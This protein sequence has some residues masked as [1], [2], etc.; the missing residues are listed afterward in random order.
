MSGFVLSCAHVLPVSSPPVKNGAVAVENGKIKALGTAEEIGKRFPSFAVR[1]LGEG[2]LLPGFVNCHTHLELGW[3]RPEGGFESFT[4]WLSHII[5]KKLRGPEPGELERSVRGGAAELMRCG[6]TTVGEISSYGADADILKNSPFRTV[7]FR[8]VTDGKPAFPARLEHG[9]R[10]EERIFPHA[11][12]SCSPELIRAAF[13]RSE[14][15]N[16]PSGIHLA[17]SPEE[18]LFVRGGKNGITEKIYPLLGK[19]PM[20][21]HTADTP[22]EYLEKTGT[23]KTKIT[24]VHMA[25]VTDGEIRRAGEKNMGVVLCPGSNR[26]LGTG[27]A[28]ALK[29]AKIKRV[30]IGTDGLSSNTSLNFFNEMKLLRDMLLPLGEDEAAKTAVRMA[31]LGGAEALFLEDRIG[32]ATPGKDADLIFIR[33]GKTDDPYKAVVSANSAETVSRGR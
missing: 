21:R 28:P 27:D 22:F 11:P 32:S 9:G 30:G 19:P 10:Y 29:Y 1:E 7:L 12:Y 31:T 23:G 25:H 16:I 13:A 4:G 2:V 17:E 33:T 6:V 14:K 18:T 24:L 3:L 5:T 15:E 8:E 20:E 26:F